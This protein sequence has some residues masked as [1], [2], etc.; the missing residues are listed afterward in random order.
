MLLN[1]KE[2]LE[3]KKQREIARYES[4]W[5]KAMERE[6]HNL[7]HKRQRKEPVDKRVGKLKAK[8]LSL[9]Q[10]YAKLSRAIRSTEWPKIFLVDKQ[11]RVN[12]N[13]NVHWWH[14]FWQKNHPQL[15]FE[16][17]NIRPI[18]YITNRTQSDQDAQW[19]VNLPKEDQEYL[20]EKSKNKSE[21]RSERNRQFY[22]AIIEKYTKLV[23]IEEERL[24]INKKKD[25]VNTT[26]VD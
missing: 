8:A 22:E 17:R 12:L 9:I 20:K 18:H 14:C 1:R 23:E 25:K 19:I 15:A 26:K 5:K 2:K 10:R 4:K 21:K 7:T 6:L 11:K 24:A 16:V 13:K 3:A